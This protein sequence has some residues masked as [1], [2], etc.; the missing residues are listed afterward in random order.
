MFHSKAKKKAP[1]YRYLSPTLMGE[2]TDLNHYLAEL[3]AGRVVFDPGSKVMH[4]STDQSS[5]KAR[6]QFRMS[7]KHLTGLYQKFGPVAY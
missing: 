4:A 6:S 1:A 2:G 3:C 5:V 7:V